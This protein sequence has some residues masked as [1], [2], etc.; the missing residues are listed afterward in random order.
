MTDHTP[1]EVVTENYAA[2]TCTEPGSQSCVIYCTECGEEISRQSVEIPAT[3]HSY[4]AQAFAPTCTKDG[5]TVWTCSVCGDSYTES[6][7]PALGH[8]WGEAEYL[9]SEDLNQVTARAICTHDPAHVLEQ[10]VQTTYILTKPSTYKEAGE[11]CYIAEFESGVFA[12]QKRT[13]VIPAVGC[14]GGSTCPSL[15][16]T[17]RP[18][19]NNWAHIPIDWAV[20]NGIARGTSKTTFS[21]KATCTRAQFLTFLWRV[22][23]APE[24]ET[25]NCPFTDVRQT[26][27]YYQAVLWA[28]ENNITK[29]TSKDKF[30]PNRDCTR[31]QVVT[32]L[33]RYAGC[34]A[35]EGEAFPFTDVKESRFSYPAILWAVGENIA[36]GTS[37]TTFS[38]GKNC[39]RA[40]CV[41]FLYRKFAK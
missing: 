14:D 33:W 38:P 9:W 6:G 22:A 11:G 34:P 35:S 7:E 5:Y 2:P 25:E 13:V 19:A 20:V 21:P 32:F 10:T 18:A 41:T 4:Q 39:T 26:A 16:F 29:G 27:Y 23:G 8:N 1:G 40:E 36:T 31:E 28:V 17:D 30:S 3:G 24:P 37:A 12:T 15:H